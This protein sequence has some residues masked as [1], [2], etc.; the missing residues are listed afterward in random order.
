MAVLVAGTFAFLHFNGGE[1]PTKAD[2]KGS[3]PTKA[4]SPKAL[5]TQGRELLSVAAPEDDP[6]GDGHKADGSWLTS[7]SYASGGPFSVLGYDL[8]SG[9]QTWKVPLDGNV[10]G[11]S[12]DVTRKGYVAVSFAGSKKARSK[13]TEFAV[14]DINEGRK[15]WQKSLPD[16]AL[17]LD[18]S[19]AVTEDFAAVGWPDGTSWGF[20]IGTGETVWDSPPQ[21]CGYEELHG[22][23]TVTSTAYCG[24][25]MTVTQRD[26]GTGKPS[27]TIKLPAG[28]LSAYVASTDPLVVAA[29]VGDGS[30]LEANRLFTFDPD[31]SIKATIKIDGYVSSCRA[32]GCHTV[33][34]SKD[35][36]Y[37]PSEKEHL[38]NGNHIA[39]FDTDTG[40]RK[41]T[42]DSADSAVL[43]PLR[44]DEDG[45]VAYNN[46][47]TGGTGS[48]VLHFA[49]ADGKQTVLLKQ[50]ETFEVQDTTAQMVDPSLKEMI[51][52]E[53]GRLF[54]HRASSFYT[55][56]VP[57]TYAFTVH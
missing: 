3:A 52:F 40:R 18:L 26:P 20:A 45:V 33:A 32:T 47:G 38:T 42:V 50:P 17:W 55:R 21:G 39:A 56:D 19:V 44:A 15:L 36:I 37:L 35:T 23:S 4:A 12:R 7:R 2:G 51:L 53:D 57:M 9:K 46:A 6:E 22:G 30:G 48:G 1:Q 28:L 54:F 13:C 49:A 31:G 43:L 24:D 25:R 29:Q 41:W 8:D 27:R 14:I 34:A 16:A 5:P 11:T 10:C